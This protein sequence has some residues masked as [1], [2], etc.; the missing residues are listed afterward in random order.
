M[1]HTPSSPIKKCMRCGESE[2]RSVCSHFNNHFYGAEH[3]HLEGALLTK[4]RHSIQPKKD[5]EIVVFLIGK[6]DAEILFSKKI[7]N[8]R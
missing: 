3:V 1:Q 7:K 6:A 5:I 4:K 8:S 2:R